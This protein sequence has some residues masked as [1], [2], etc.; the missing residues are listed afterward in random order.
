MKSDFLF[1]NLLENAYKHGVEKLA[2]HAFVKIDLHADREQL[3]FSIVNNVDPE[4]SP[5]EHGIGLANL[6]K[7]LALH[8]PDQHLLKIT[9]TDRCYSA[10][11][12]LAVNS[13]KEH[14]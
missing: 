9:Q 3:M 1:I 11:L 5:K 12:T 13:V 14:Q 4:E 10:T 2:D 7:R 8:S 6:R